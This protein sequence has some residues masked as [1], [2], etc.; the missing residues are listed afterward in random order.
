MLFAPLHLLPVHLMPSLV[1]AKT[2]C[3]S[4]TKIEESQ[5][6]CPGHAAL[7]VM[8]D[9]VLHALPG[10]TLTSFTVYSTLSLRIRH[11]AL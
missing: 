7:I 3:F 11:C 6:P 4:T 10:T 8:T 2:G 1:Y 9:C 5:T